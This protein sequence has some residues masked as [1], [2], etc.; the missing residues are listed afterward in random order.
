MKY[1]KHLKL[2]SLFL[3]IIILLPVIFACGESPDNN[4]NAGSP[5]DNDNNSGGGETVA[6]ITEPEA[7]DPP[8]EPTTPEPTD[9]PTT[10]E[11]TEPFVPDL[12]L[13][14]W[15]QIAK[16]FEWY[17]LTGGIK[18]LNGDNEEEVINKFRA[19]NC[20]RDE[21]DIS[22]DNVPFSSAHRVTVVKDA[23]SYGSAD[24]KAQCVKDVPVNQGDLIV[25]VIWIK[26]QRLSETENYDID[27]EPQ[28][29]FAVKSM[30]DSSATEG[31]CTPS[32][33][34]YAS[35]EWRKV[36]FY[37]RVLNEED[38]SRNL[39]VR[40]FLGYGHQQLDFGGIM[41]YRFAYSKEIE[42]AAIKLVDS[43]Q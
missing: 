23:G 9:P 33:G 29:F 4:S 20:Q 27:D 10:E 18:I 3:C 2:L 35:S 38:N 21:L 42:A 39:D 40:I 43:A 41:A 1:K 11:P 28:Y 6:D 5:N 37:G 25:G 26:G 31:D 32:G 8:T 17:G 14:Y 15:E 7:T 22:G 16:E 30:T 12:S 13:P 34:Q 24:Y 36:F 19:T